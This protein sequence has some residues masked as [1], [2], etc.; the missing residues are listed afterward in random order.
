MLN[1][2]LSKLFA[3]MVAAGGGVTI[4]ININNN[5][6]SESPGANI[7]A[8]QPAPITSTNTKKIPNNKPIEDTKTPENS[9]SKPIADLNQTQ[10]REKGDIEGDERMI[11]PEE[12]G[13][14]DKLR[15]V[16][17]PKN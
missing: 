8:T 11:K 4:A 7:E 6:I 14:K 2:I 12:E 1:T 10:E 15:V 17:H 5:N 16:T 3:G 9:Q 13:F